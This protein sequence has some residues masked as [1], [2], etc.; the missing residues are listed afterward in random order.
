MARR[1]SSCSWMKFDAWTLYWARLR[2]TVVVST[3]VKTASM[4]AARA[5]AMSASIREKPRRAPSSELR[6]AM[7]R[8]FRYIGSLKLG[9]RNSELVRLGDRLRERVDRRDH[10][11]GDAADHAAE[12]KDEDRFDDRGKV[13]QDLVDLLLVE[14][15]DVGQ[16]LVDRA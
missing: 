10:G 12:R 8:V 5:M 15:R 7:V 2:N 13:V 9:A 16:Q 14:R 1:L 11:E 4:I 6:A 3:E